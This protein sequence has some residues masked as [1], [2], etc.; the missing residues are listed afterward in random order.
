MSARRLLVVGATSMRWAAFTTWRRLGIEVVLVDGHSA[1]RYEHLADEFWP[2]DA[3]DATA[4]LDAIREIGRT[5]DGVTTLADGS[6]HTA[7]AIAEDLGL[8]G[9]GRAAAS[10]A[11]SKL[12]QRALFEGTQV[13][14]PRWRHAGSADDLHAF[15]ADGARPAVLKPIDSAGS[16]G[17]LRVDGADDALRQWPVVRSLSPSH[18]VI[19]ED[20]IEGREV[21]VDAVV[22]RGEPVFVSVCEAEYTGPEGF[23]AVSALYAAD[24][25]DLAAATREIGLIASVL[26]LRD[27]T[28]HAEFKIDGDRWSLLETALRPGGALVPELTRRVRGVDLYEVMARL[29]FGEPDLLPPGGPA[30][31]SSAF[32]QVRF[33][34]GSGQVR[35]FVPP[36]EVVRGL[37]DVRIVGQFAGPGRRVRR[38]VSE[39][40]RA[41]YAVG[42]GPH[43][44]RLD[45]QLREAVSRLAGEMGLTVASAVAAPA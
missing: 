29:A 8:P 44:E 1:D 19:V 4:D 38:P 10:V 16:S 22:N 45:G 24:Q 35:R 21:C 37:P 3:R 18:T 7:A 2:L 36:G 20:Y 43:R 12:R 42:W 9:V 5:C 40:G 27:A 32:A 15:F 34:V 33:L 39:E 17:V 14:V 30:P 11:R 26:G 13:R 23:I 25:P 28:V 41:G 31:A 6:Q